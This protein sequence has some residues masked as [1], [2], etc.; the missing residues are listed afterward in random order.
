MN[1][2]LPYLSRRR[3]L[4]VGASALSLAAGR[5]LGAATEGDPF[6]GFTVGV[7]SY[8]F[9]KFDTEHALKGMRDLGLSH[10][11]L[12]PK[13]APLSSTPGQIKA[14]RDLCREYGV[15]PVAYGV[16]G[17]TRDHDANRKIFEFGKQ[18]GIN[19]FS[20]DP[21]PDSFDSLDKLVDTYKIAVAIHPHGPEAPRNSQGTTGQRKLHRWYSAEVIMRAVKDHHPL[22]GSCLDTGHLIRAA[23]LG[24]H[25]DPAEQVRIMGARNFGVH[26]KDNDNAHD[27]NVVFGKGAL[28]VAGV[29]KALKEVQ[30]KGF[31]S[32]EYEAHPD[33]PS[34]DMTACVEVLKNAVKALA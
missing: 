11:E 31:I 14:V 26:L 3:F 12:Y 24:Q 20:A 7:Q 6:G 22:I 23:E 15:K 8:S 17:F 34:P 2:A 27:V 4:Q 10:V 9:R 28:N 16:Q 1:P 5:A 25:L 30:F 19:A 29:L 18:F 21:D 13:H 32:I 33:D